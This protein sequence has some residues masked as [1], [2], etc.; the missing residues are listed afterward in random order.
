MDRLPANPVIRGAFARSAL[1][2]RRALQGNNVLAIRGSVNEVGP[3]LHER[4]PFFEHVV[5]HV[6][7]SHGW[8]TAPHASVNHPVALIQPSFTCLF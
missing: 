3:I 1:T 2:C 4:A 5:S 6:S 7:L 8:R